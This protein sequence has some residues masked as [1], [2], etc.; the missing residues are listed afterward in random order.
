MLTL[1]GTRNLITLPIDLE[2][3]NPRLR[4][5]AS[6]DCTSGHPAWTGERTLRPGSGLSGI[7]ELVYVGDPVY[8]A[9]LPFWFM[10]IR[11][12]FEAICR[13]DTTSAIRH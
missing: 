5:A 4:Y 3:S 10:G 6:A 11:P 13:S 12:A 8:A 2:P 1:S 9:K 7:T